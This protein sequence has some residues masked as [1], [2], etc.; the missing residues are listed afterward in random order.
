MTG[1]AQAARSAATQTDLAV[2]TLGRALDPT[3][4]LT[5]AGGSERLPANVPE[6]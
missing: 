5:I 3:I 4:Q 2:Q 6:L 1:L